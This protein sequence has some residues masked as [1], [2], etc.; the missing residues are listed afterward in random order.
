[1]DKI[2]TH[3]Q[4]APAARCGVLRYWFESTRVISRGGADLAAETAS[5]LVVLAGTTPTG[6]GSR[7][8]LRPRRYGGSGGDGRD[9]IGV[10]G[11]EP[12]RP[13]PTPR[14]RGSGNNAL[15]HGKEGGQEGCMGTSFLIV[16]ND[17]REDAA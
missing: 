13:I 1:M 4:M 11:R 17:R 16:T 2:F 10:E 8:C 7:S 3:K 15:S 12:E 14:P 9:G 6:V 5:S